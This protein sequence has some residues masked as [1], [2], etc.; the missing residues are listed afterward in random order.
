[1]NSIARKSWLKRIEILL[2]SGGFL[3]AAFLLSIHLKAV[4]AE[5]SA[6]SFGQAQQA[7]GAI[8]VNPTDGTDAQAHVIGKLEIR[9][10]S[11]SVPILSNYEASS[12]LKG[13]G[14]IPGTALP[15]GLGTLGLAGHRDTYFRPLRGIKKDMDIR[16]SDK[17]GVYH[18]EVDSTEIVTPDDVQV[19]AVG[20]RPG[21]T[22]VTCYPFYFIGSAPKRFIVHAHLLSVVP[23]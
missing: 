6:A 14:H 10:L 13:I 21:L 18:Y 17:T 12:L 16:V 3:C 5:H 23:D 11:L 4:Q 7:P 15:G 1:M 9:A 22:L 8:R 20:D 19:L 2:L